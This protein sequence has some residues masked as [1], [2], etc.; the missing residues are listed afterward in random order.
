MSSTKP[1]AIDTMAPWTIKAFPTDARRRI[2]RAA[3]IQ[4]VTVG[5]WIEQRLLEWEAAG[6]ENRVVNHVSP[7]NHVANPVNGHPSDNW[8]RL[9]QVAAS[10]T[11]V[12][13]LRGE[14][15]R[16]V[17]GLLG[18]EAPKG[19]PGARRRLA[20]PESRDGGQEAGRA[21]EGG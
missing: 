15:G 9:F 3:E 13:W 5:Q 1:A 12:K 2:V 17:G 11:V 20:A 19:R 4:G 7:E 18:I 14:A 10:P 16:R 21:G 8:D 6:S